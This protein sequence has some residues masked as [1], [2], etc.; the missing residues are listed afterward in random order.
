[1]SHNISTA[2]VPF[3]VRHLLETDFGDFE[4]LEPTSNK[5]FIEPEWSDEDEEGNLVCAP[6]TI[7]GWTR[8]SDH[9]DEP[10]SIL[11]YTWVH[12]QHGH[13]HTVNESKCSNIGECDLAVFATNPLAIEAFIKDNFPKC[14]NKIETFA[15]VHSWY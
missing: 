5:W 10:S 1:M 2:V 4:E 13:V 14:K 11:C 9:P 7:N 3:I 6:T 15:V 12:E 8:T